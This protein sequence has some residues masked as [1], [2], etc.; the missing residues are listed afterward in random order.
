MRVFSP[1]TEA[2]EYE[3]RLW[4]E[5]HIIEYDSNAHRMKGT[6]ASSSHKVYKM[7]VCDYNKTGM[8]LT[9]LF[10]FE[11]GPKYIN[12]NF[13]NKNNNRSNRGSSNVTANQ[14]ISNL[15]FNFI[16]WSIFFFLS[17]GRAHTRRL[18]W[19]V[20]AEHGKK[21][22]DASKAVLGCVHVSTFFFVRKIDN[23]CVA[24]II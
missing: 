23:S 9:H 7:T 6:G 15:L 14:R 24:F 21:L 19:K 10:H 2:T 8:N 12:Y 17:G 18:P 22:R 4:D 20:V 1:H 5:K 11:P 16:L 3:L 13:A